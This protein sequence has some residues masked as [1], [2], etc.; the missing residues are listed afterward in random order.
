MYDDRDERPSRLSQA[1]IVTD[2]RTRLQAIRSAEFSVLVPPPVPGLGQAGGFQMM[3]ED[4]SSAGLRELQKA[5]QAVL[6]HADREPG[7]GCVTTAFDTNSPQLYLDVDRT[8]AESLGVTINDVFQTL[9][10]YLGSSY[11]NRFN[12]FNQSFEVRVQ[13]GADARRRLHDVAGL[14]VANRSGQMVPLR[15]CCH[16]GEPASRAERMS[17]R[18]PRPRPRP[19]TEASG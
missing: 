4:R 12:K 8:M 19:S 1:R 7:L 2:L 18:R 15:A 13:A 14:Y 5:V 3:V 11:V 17:R 6:L 10:T 16:F 9:Q